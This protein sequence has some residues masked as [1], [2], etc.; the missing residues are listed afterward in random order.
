MNVFGGGG[1]PFTPL[2]QFVAF[3]TSKRRAAGEPRPSRREHSSHGPF[4]QTEVSTEHLSQNEFTPAGWSEELEARH[5][6]HGHMTQSGLNGLGLVPKKQR[7]SELY[8]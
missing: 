3:K 5:T 1:L 4:K 6:K 7:W 2:V 8:G